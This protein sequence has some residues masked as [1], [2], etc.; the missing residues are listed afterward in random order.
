[1]ASKHWVSGALVCLE[2]TLSPV[3]HETNEIDWKVLLSEKKDRLTEHLIAF[4]N[5]SNGGFLAFGVGDGG[6]HLEPVGQ[7]AVADIAN[8]LANLGRDAVEPPLV[9]DH[10]VV[11]FRGVP[12]L[13]VR[14]PEQRN[15]PAHRR[16]KSIEES[17]VRSGGTTRKASRQEVGA[18]MLNSTAPRWEELRASDLLSIDGAIE[19]LDLETIAKLLQRPVPT[20]Q[21]ALAQWLTDERII[22]PDGRGYYVTNFGAVAAARKLE[23]FPSL[24]RKRIRVIRYRGM[25]K[26]ETIDELPGQRG[27]AVGFEGLIDYL[28]RILPHSEVIQQ[29][30]RTELTVYPE[31]AL[32]EL[33]ANALIHQDFTVTGA[34]PMV[35]VFDDR[36]EFTNP[37]A[38][39]PGKRPDRL[40]GTTPESR[41]ETLAS[42]FRRYRICEER[43]TGFQKV[44]RSVELFGLPPIAFSP[45]ENA[46]RV[47]LYA[48]RKFAEMSQA[49]RIEACY[50][51]AVLQYLSSQSL[52]NTTLRE[53][54]RLHEKQRNQVTNLIGDAVAAGRIKRKDAG[55]GKQ[56]A[57]YV[58]Y[59]I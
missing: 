38:L 8:T 22:T 7:K 43:G 20:E 58:P 37:G 50:Q 54:F 32:R 3:P 25:N 40:I 59:W 42:A 48:P 57:E 12:L 24:E 41:N 35:D 28:K 56:F 9:I 46:F 16:G 17:W 52:T 18:L 47:T 26:V 49:E 33:I 39:L 13:L 45:M 27:Y 5:Y 36:I 15:K 14:I 30:L 1:M 21:D 19:R 44:V 10:A 31:I 2:E 53:R 6:A 51:H 34:G 11:E 29:S 4:A 23:Q 55:S